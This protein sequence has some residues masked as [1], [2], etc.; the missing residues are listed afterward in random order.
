M[1][2]GL[3]FRFFSCFLVFCLALAPA[4]LFAQEAEP[5]SDPSSPPTSLLW[6]IGSD[7]LSSSIESLLRL[8]PMLTNIN[9]WTTSA[10]SWMQRSEELSQKESENLMLQ[11]E[12][13][14]R[15]S[16]TSASLN[17]FM[18]RFEN[19]MNSLLQSQKSL[20]AEIWFY[21]VALALAA[22][23]IVYLVIR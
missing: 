16:Q 8:G 20:M 1:C 3:R 6:Q 11:S 23:G 9:A 12:N 15:L 5:T 7:A 17:E 10:E 21:R 22:G 19:I 4:F 13:I 18:P 2:G 14:T